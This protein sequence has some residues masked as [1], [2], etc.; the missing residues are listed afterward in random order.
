MKKICKIIVAYLSLLIT[1]LMFSCGESK[2]EK[3]I[4]NIFIIKSATLNGEDVTKT[5]T[6][7]R[8]EFKKDKTMR[9]VIGYLGNIVTRNSTYSYIGNTITENFNG[10][11]ISYN[12]KG[13]NLVT[14]MTDF[15]DIISIELQPFVDNGQEEK[16]VNFEGVLFGKDI[17]QC[18]IFNY[19]PAVIAEKD[20]NGRGIMHI[21]Y[22]TNKDDGAIMDHIGYRQGKEQADGKWSFSKQSIVLKPTENTWDARHTC[23]PAV[24]KGNFKYQNKQYNWLMAY[25]GCITSDY[26]NNET[27]IA[28]AENPE[29][30]WIKVDRL[31]PIIPWQDGGINDNGQWN[32]GTGMPALISLDTKGQV[33]L[34]YKSGNRGTAVQKWDFSDLDK[35]NLEPEFQVTLSGKGLVNSV[36]IKCGIGI[37][38]FAYDGNS[39]R[40][41]LCATTN[42][43]NPPD[44]TITRVN[45]HC[46]VACIENISSLSQLCETLK[47]EKYTWKVIG[48]IGPSDT[49]FERNHNPA[50]VR[51]CY[52]YIHPK[53]KI[54]V[55]IST[56]RNDRPQD[57]IFT[58]RLCGKFVY[59]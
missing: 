44:K 7:Y 38:D 2:E 56:G 42:E 57:N 5:F 21:W 43:K 59:L 36:N 48:Y 41:Y 49:G 22:C 20:E 47:G 9:V 23:D 3:V 26:G 29:G 13:K 35:Y 34:F 33:L 50:L 46:L 58:Y 31:N 14:N 27:G 54:G 1:F 32:W 53:D 55:I 51:D 17:N 6:A 28:V 25:L 18:K 52:G 12:F 19:C 30:P 24:V 40:F 45:S 11:K 10:E 16:A 39:K 15:E 8:V 4:E 37:P